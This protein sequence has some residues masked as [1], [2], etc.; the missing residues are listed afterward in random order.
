VRH[1][2]GR[3]ARSITN[4]NT[5]RVHDPDSIRQGA[6]GS[7]N[8]HTRRLHHITRQGPTV[9]WYVGINYVRC[10]IGCQWPVHPA[11]PVRKVIVSVLSSYRYGYTRGD[12]T[13]LGRQQLYA[14]V[15][16]SSAEVFQ[17]VGFAAVRHGHSAHKRT[18]TSETSEICTAF[19]SF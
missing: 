15:R 2:H 16:I 19:L 18:S 8:V 9:F 14:F 4:H 12:L 6:I 1:G 13:P 17:G 7:S 10:H 5:T 3:G 11:V